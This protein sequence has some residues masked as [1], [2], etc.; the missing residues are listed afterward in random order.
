MRAQLE[1]TAVEEMDKCCE[2]VLVLLL[3]N[4]DNAAETRSADAYLQ[5]SQRDHNCGRVHL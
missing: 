1:E 4:I 5:L 2:E 3:I